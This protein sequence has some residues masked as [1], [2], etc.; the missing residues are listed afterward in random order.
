MQFYYNKEPDDQNDVKIIAVRC[1]TCVKETGPPMNNKN[2]NQKDIITSFV[3]NTWLHHVGMS[4]IIETHE[5]LKYG[6]YKHN[7]DWITG[8]PRYNTSICK[9][10][11]EHYL[12]NIL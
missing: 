11:M 10:Y 4:W 5:K 1:S 9:N 12:S 7:Q 3:L 6:K 2:I 8:G